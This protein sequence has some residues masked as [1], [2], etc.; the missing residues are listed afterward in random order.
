M[1]EKVKLIFNPHANLGRAQ[2]LATPLH[3]LLPEGGSWSETAY[4]NHAKE[5]AFQ[6]ASEGYSLVIAV[7]GDGT[8]HEVL[9]GL[10]QA[11]ADS[12]PALGIV[13]TGSGN[14]F[15]FALGVPQDPEAALRRVLQGT[16]LTVDIGLT[17][18]DNGQAFYWSNAVGIGFDTIVTIHSRHIPVVQG[19]ALYFA[20][21]LQTILLNYVPFHIHGKLDGQDWEDESMMMVLC[22]GQREGGGFYVTPAGKPDDGLLDFVSVGRMSRLRMLMT[23]PHFMKP[24]QGSLNKIQTGQF[25]TLELTSDKPLY[26]HTDGEILAGFGSNVHQIRTEILPCALK[27]MR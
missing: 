20:A 1:A 13:P 2:A 23:L 11:P 18:L 6:A 12:R 8:V 16:P 19:F 25:H 10:M 22:N 17:S 26:I 15:S 7:G 21:V 5:I 4:P 27:M 14:D 3:A 24:A 9:N